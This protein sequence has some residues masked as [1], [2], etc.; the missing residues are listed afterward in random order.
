MSSHFVL[1][2]REASYT[3]APACA[4]RDCLDQPRGATLRTAPQD[5]GIGATPILKSSLRSSDRDKT[6]PHDH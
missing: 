1:S 5:E 2:H 6:L 4:K 3:V